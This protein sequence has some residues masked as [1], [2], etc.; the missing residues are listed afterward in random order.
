MP[1][2]SNQN[3]LW[4]VRIVGRLDGQETNNVLHFRYLSGASDTDVELHL[5]QVLITCFI[6]H[7]LPVV[8]SSWNFEKV[9]WKRVSPT[10]GP[11]LTSVPT[12]TTTGGGAAAALPSFASAVFS[13]RTHEGGR[14]KRG[15]MYLAGIPENATINSTLDPAHAFWAGLLAFALCIVENFIPGDPVGSN[16]YGMVVYSRKIGGAA[17][18]YGL[19]GATQI[20]EIFP[21]SQIG[22]TRSRKVGRGS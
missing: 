13:I 18:P 12:G 10:L 7:I 8:T 21:V 19:N 17:F 6:T 11:E 2:T 15:R 20:H 3:D 14:S 22:T 1:E 4:Q 9:V 5:I 16:S